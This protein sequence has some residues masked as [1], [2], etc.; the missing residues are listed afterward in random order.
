MS[1]SE[2]KEYQAFDKMMNS[3]FDL[4]EEINGREEDEELTE[5][6]E[7][8]LDAFDNWCAVAVEMNEQEENVVEE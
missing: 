3:L 6:E 5:N 7:K 2:D 8:F 4:A 1:N